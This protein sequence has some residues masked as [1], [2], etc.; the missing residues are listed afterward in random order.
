MSSITDA[1]PLAQ[2]ATGARCPECLSDA[3]VNWHHDGDLCPQHDRE[4]AGALARLARYGARLDTAPDSRMGDD[5]MAYGQAHH[6]RQADYRRAWR[7][8]WASSCAPDRPM[9]RDG[10]VIMARRT[11]A[12][13]AWQWNTDAFVSCRLGLW[14]GYGWFPAT[15]E[16]R[17]VAAC[18]RL[19]M[20]P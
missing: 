10:A 2:P 8:L 5:L 9:W 13:V 11:L 16:A 15:Y 12:Q 4:D 14:G 7:I 1:P 17:R 19:G 6:W 18:T 20:R 3:E